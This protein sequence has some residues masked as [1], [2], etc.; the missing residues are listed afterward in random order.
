MSAEVEMRER[1]EGAVDE[2]YRRRFP[3]EV[4]P[5]RDAVWRV[6]CEDWFSR[7]VP[8]EAQVLEVAAGYCEFINN[9]EAAGRYAVDLNPE[10][11]AHAAPGVVVHE[12][13]AARVADVLPRAHFD[14]AFMSNFLE[15]CR[16]R[17]EVLAVLRGV[18]RVLKPG[19]RVLVLGPNFRYCSKEYFDYFDHYLPLTEKSVSEALRLAGFEIEEAT[20]RTLPFTFK[21]RLPSAPWLVRLYLRLPF[22][23][24]IFGAQFF[25]VGRK[26]A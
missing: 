20:A 18:G 9:V 14:V 15:H 21:S 25:V 7:Y 24:R 2:L 13:S 12:A 19:G 11:A 22:L 1:L 10:T 8:R 4:R 23:W 6:L 26:A 16:T 3:A 17:D 5:R